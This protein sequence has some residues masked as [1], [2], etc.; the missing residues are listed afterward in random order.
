[1]SVRYYRLLLALAASLSLTLAGCASGPPPES[2]ADPVRGAAPKPPVQ[3]AKAEDDSDETLWTWL[4]LSKRPSAL[5]L[6]PQTGR[7][8]S[9]VLWEA[10]L[11]A[12]KFAGLSAEDP[13]TGLIVTKWYSP[14]NKP[15]ERLRVSVFILSRALRSDS[16]SVT[17]ERETRSP[18]GTWQ[19]TP[20][21]RDV[22]DAIDNTIL[23][24]AQ[25]IHAT[26]YRESTYN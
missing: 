7:T 16:V 14:P 9:P 10:S 26:R 8:V 18:D 21:A 6:G 11:D 19:K 12:L 24:R 23:E 3:Q 4:G 5:K 1:M 13:T 25:E 2:A 20:V 17:V 22:V 15:D